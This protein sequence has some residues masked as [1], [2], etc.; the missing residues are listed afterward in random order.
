MV[1]FL[2]FGSKVEKR[3][4]RGR[5]HPRRR[6]TRNFSYKPF[7]RLSEQRRG[8]SLWKSAGWKRLADFWRFSKCLFRFFKQLPLKALLCPYNS[9]WKGSSPKEAGDGHRLPRVVLA[10]GRE[11]HSFSGTGTSWG[12]AG[13][14]G[15]C[16]TRGKI[17]QAGKAHGPEERGKSWWMEKHPDTNPGR[18]FLF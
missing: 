4:K 8:S 17:W 14:E 1:T 15:T 11:Q 18:I 9:R 6:A 3:K 16:G 2:F 5:K 10:A 12:G 7:V 13:R